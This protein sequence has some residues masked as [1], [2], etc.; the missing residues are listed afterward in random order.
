MPPAWVVAAAATAA[1][2]QSIGG[3]RGGGN[4]ARPVTVN[5]TPVD[6]PS[7]STAAAAA[8]ASIRTNN[9]GVKRQS[10]DHQQP[11]RRQPRQQQPELR[12]PW[13]QQPEL[14]QSWKPRVRQQQRRRNKRHAASGS[15][16]RADPAA[17]GRRWFRP[18]R[19]RRRSSDPCFAARLPAASR[20]AGAPGRP[21]ALPAHALRRRPLRRDLSRPAP[22]LLRRPLAAFRSAHR[23]RRGGD[24][25]RLLLCGRLRGGAPAGLRRLHAGRLPAE[26]AAVQL[27]GR[28]QR[29]AVRAILPAA[30]RPAAGAARGADRAAAA[31][32]GRHVRGDDL[33]RARRLPAPAS[34]PATSSPSSATSAGT[35]RSRRSR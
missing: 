21:A 5:P 4:V 6:R 20:Q 27:R 2:E 9:G 7:P 15:P 23:A 16:R 3:N 22:V 14:R 26:L 18:A 28:R 17:H 13:Q 12:Q 19:W 29:M 10:S 1:A 35:T 34:P 31:P 30:E 11:E 32:A 25:R 8:A 24:R 33:L